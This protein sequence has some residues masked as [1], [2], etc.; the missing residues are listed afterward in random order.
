MEIMREEERTTIKMCK[1]CWS[2][3][4]SPKIITEKVTMAQ[5]LLMALYEAHG[6]GGNLHILVD[7]FN[8]KDSDVDWCGTF[9]LDDVERPVIDLFKSMTVDERGSALAMFENWFE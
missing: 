7:D 1:G 2:G 8:I 6:A 4:G 5:G 3:Y 9:E